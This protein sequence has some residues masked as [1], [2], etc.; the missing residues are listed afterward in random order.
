MRL[1]KL[2]AATF[3]LP[4]LVTAQA[5]PPAANTPNLTE[6]EGH[7]EYRDGATAFLGR[8]AQP[9]VGSRL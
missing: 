7:Y 1:C 4:S 9:P 3:L 6:F 5:G 8:P 2:V